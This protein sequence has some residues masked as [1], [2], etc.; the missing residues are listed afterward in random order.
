MWL[1]LVSLAHDASF[2][3]EPS[4][5]V[6]EWNILRELEIESSVA[7]MCMPGVALAAILN[8]LKENVNLHKKHQY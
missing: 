7:A 3:S 2:D 1:E 6:P 4:Q 8:H 5:A